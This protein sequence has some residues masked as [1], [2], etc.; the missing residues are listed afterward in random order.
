MAA[1]L[2]SGCLAILLIGAKLH[3]NGEKGISTHTELGLAACQFEKRTGLPCPSCGFT[4]SVTYFAH[5]N[6]LASIYIQ[7]MG[8]VIALFASATVWIGFYIAL[9]GKPVHRLLER[10]PGKAWLLGL[11][12]IAVVAW[13][14][15]IW[16]HLT[17]HD[18]WPPV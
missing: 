16:I 15:K 2:A 4:T 18:H 13:A 11:L 9:T 8:F 17:L 10:L 1:G 14:W 3:P 7:P 6:V 12:S 5:G